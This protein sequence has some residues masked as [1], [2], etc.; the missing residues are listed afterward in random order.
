MALDDPKTKKILII[1]DDHHQLDIVEHLL[2]KEGFQ[3]VTSHSADEVKSKVEAISPDLII[4][5]MIM[6]GMSG[7][8]FI[9]HLQGEG[10]GTIPVIVV[11]GRYTDKIS[12]DEQMVRM[13]SNVVDLMRKPLRLTMFSMRVHQVLKTNPAPIRQPPQSPS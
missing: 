11:T 2:Q 13:E 3:T 1:D 10:L 6:P 5:D 7:M 12:T 4:C 8:E 9:R